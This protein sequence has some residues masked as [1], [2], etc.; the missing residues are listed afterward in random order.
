MSTASSARTHPC[1]RGDPLPSSADQ[2]ALATELR[3]FILDSDVP[4]DYPYDI[5]AS[6]GKLPHVV[7]Y[8][9]PFYQVSGLGP[10]PAD[11]ANTSAGDVYIDLSPAQHALYG[12][13]A[14]GTWK[15]WFDP[16]PWVKTDAHCVRHPHFS[17]TRKLW[18]SS[19]RGISW[20]TSNTVRNNQE[21][22]NQ[23][24]LVSRDAHKTEQ[25]RWREAG[26]L[27]ELSL[28]DELKPA[29]PKAATPPPRSSTSCSPPFESREA[30]PAPVPGKRKRTQ[31]SAGGAE[32]ARCKAAL[33]KAIQR[34]T[35]ESKE[36]AATISALETQHDGLK[37][38]ELAIKNELGPSCRDYLD[39]EAALAFVEAQLSEE[40]SMHEDAQAA[41]N[42]MISEDEECVK[43]FE[44]AT[45]QLERAFG[46]A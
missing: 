19:A 11:L 39:L 23:R 16:Q 3:Y 37:T 38:K 36:L 34:L 1:F 14:D 40:D 32:A 21:R 4:S 25:T 18:C 31:D 46:W 7:C 33:E 20:Y 41:L 26:V 28:A 45:S 22:A 10:P 2:L 8:H 24:G 9:I 44:H 6:P 30:S 13:L 43:Q 27:I 35:A 15:R 12:H 42:R 17:G 5:A 29:E